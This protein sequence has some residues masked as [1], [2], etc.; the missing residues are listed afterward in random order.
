M[1]CT[2]CKHENRDNAKFCENCGE[3]LSFICPKCGLELKPEAKFCDEC[4]TKVGDT[5]PKITIPSLEE[6]HAGIQR[7][8]PKSMLQSV[9]SQIEGENRIL[10]IL[11]GDIS[12]SVGIT[13]K[14]NPEDAADLINECLKTMVD[15]I[16]KYE[17]RINRFL[18]DCVLAFFGAPVSHENDSERAILAALEMR[19][20][21]AK[22]NLN[23]SIGINTGMVY[24][25]AM[26]TDEH[27]EFTA[28]G[29]AVNL[30]SRLQNIASTGQIIVGET[31]YRLTRRSFEFQ[32]LPS[33]EVRGISEPI[34]AYEVI[35]T[36]PKFEKIRGIEGLRAD[37]IGRDKEFT[38]LKDSVGELLNGRGQI[39]SIIGEAG[40]GKSRLVKEFKEYIADAN[41][42]STPICLE[43]Q[44]ISIGESMS[45]WVFIDIL[46]NYLEFS[47]DDNLDTLRQKTI[48]KMSSL[49]PQR[50][51]EIMS[52]IGNLLSLEFGNEWDNKVKNMSADIVKYQTFMALRDVFVAISQQ[53]PLILIL[54]D[55]H[56]GDNLSL[57]LINLLMDTLTLAHIMLIC[58][59]RPDKDHKSSHISAQASSKCLDRYKEITLHP[60]TAQ[61]SRRLIESLLSIENLPDAIKENILQKA[62]GNPFFVEEVI[63]SLME[64][65]VI[66]KD[67][68]RWIAKDEIK[69][70]AVPDTVQNVIMSRI[71]RLEE[72]TRY[73]LQSASVIG[74]LFRHR[75]LQYITQRE[76]DLDKHLW[77]LEESDLVYEEQV[78]PELEYGFKH[79]LT[80]E[81]AYNT[82]LSRRRRE[83]HGK[84]AEGYE[85]LYSS[86]IEEYYDDLAY[87]YSRSDDHLKAVQYLVKAGEK[88][89]RNYSN[90][91]AI[92][93]YQKALEIIEQEKIEQ[94]EWKLEAL[95]GLGEVY[96]GTSRNAEALKVFEKAVALAKEMRL[97]PRRI[98]M[99]Y[100]WITESLYWLD[101]SN[102]ALS[103]AEKG[104]EELGDDT[105]CLEAVLM[106]D[107]IIAHYIYSAY[108]NN[109]EKV[110]EYIDRNKAIIRKLPYSPELRP[111][112][113][114]IILYAWTENELDSSWEW[115]KELEKLAAQHNDLHGVAEAWYY[116]GTICAKKGDFIA[117]IQYMQRSIEMLERIGDNVRTL[118]IRHDI[119]DSFF[120]I[121][122]IDEAGK[123]AQKRLQIFGD[124][125][126]QL[127]FAIYAYYNLSLAEMCK[128]NYDKALDYSKKGFEWLQANGWLWAVSRAH[129]HLGLVY[130]KKGDFNNA[131]Q[132][133]ELYLKTMMESTSESL[134]SQY[135]YV[136]L[137]LLKEAYEAISA[138]E[139][140]REYCLSLKERYADAIE[141]LPSFKFDL[142]TIQPSEEYR[143][144]IFEDDFQGK[145]EES[146]SW[147]D[148]F[149]DCSYR[150][151]DDGVEIHSA[152]GRDLNGINNS[153]PRLMR[154]V[155]D[156]FAVET[157][158][159]SVSDEKPQIGGILL[160]KDKG[161][162]LRLERGYW[163]KRTV[164][165]SGCVDGKPYNC[166]HGFLSYAGDDIYLRLERSGSK[167]HAYCNSD[168]KK[169]LSC[170]EIELQAEDPIQVGI[171]AYGMIDRHIYC[172]SFKEGTA[173]LFRKFRLWKRSIE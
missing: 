24:V 18:G 33:L 28:M 85:T 164:S 72:E 63:R 11:F 163:G 134:I 47:A 117:N 103:H 21:V 17:G 157:V 107:K 120:T 129:F 53:K 130:M 90:D 149:G 83:F 121:G 96:D 88:A 79:A 61:E 22:L 55:L 49:F 32:P 87:H 76:R 92:A 143:N 166:S 10:S 34:S 39:V 52:Y 150:L 156:D 50:Q 40:V 155:T 29:T 13:E 162:F 110:K 100:Y 123:H 54:E 146:W 99:L 139:K 42:D 104:L 12:N 60:L 124:S 66:Y 105:E 135:Y 137:I 141:K 73:V 30:A 171:Y 14:M 3:K 75:L 111:S 78:I 45:Y 112:Y 102:E 68:D 93:H 82:I 23:I 173:T 98:V 65:G 144:L 95:Q 91:V 138:P 165:Y 36:L 119:I 58:V 132:N 161:N 116:Q 154:E 8:T 37:M 153:A 109:K 131:I 147:I 19:D 46:R 26:G 74:R 142:E 158:V 118:P 168:G 2:K 84:V 25:G 115:A 70:I 43:G 101:R 56:W 77:Q 113:D 6:I 41:L 148:E 57:D 16:V 69:N 1:Q 51:D 71:D 89:R 127:S 145:V 125:K 48:E 152:N 160:W 59:Y 128:Q 67:G 44:C 4:G 86:R 15:V 20:E 108:Y 94:N 62:E 114:R 80:Q 172:G 106:N 5:A 167:F 140:Y 169:W 136:P 170:G 81:T 38:D 159:S 35:K 151:T 9:T 64:S 31:T 133:L 7:S 97:P 126:S 27:K 122:D